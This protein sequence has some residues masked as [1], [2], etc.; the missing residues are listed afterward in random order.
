MGFVNGVEDVVVVD[1]VSKIATVDAKAFL[2]SK[3][4]QIEMNKTVEVERS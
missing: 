1:T 3:G 2:K 4:S